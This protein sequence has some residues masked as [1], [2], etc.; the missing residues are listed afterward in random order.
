[1]LFER[2]GIDFEFGRA[3]KGRNRVIADLTRTNSLFLSTASQNAHDELLKISGFFRQMASVGDTQRRSRNNLFDEEMPDIDRRAIDFLSRLGTGVVDCR[4]SER[5]VPRE[6]RE[7]MEQLD[8]MRTKLTGGG[9]T[10]SPSEQPLKRKTLELAHKEIGGSLVYWDLDRESEGTRRLL[11]LLRPMLN[12][13]DEGSLLI[14]DELD[15]SL[16]TQA[17]EA[18]LLL[19][20]SAGTNPK[21]A[22][23]VATTHDTNLLQCRL[24]RRD[25]IWFTEKNQQ[26][27]TDLYPLTDFRTRKGD[28]LE[29]GYLQGR[30]GA[31]PF[32]GAIPSF[33]DAS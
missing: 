21:G 6:V 4:I 16:H 29:R 27:A 31:V 28:R 8:G 18:L 15:A 33:Q 9:T 19:F 14:V 30:Y 11:G 1:L 26:G 13:L 7:F 22:Q 3:L 20:L 17:C 25:Q 2:Q 10:S 23:L 12:A 32:A 24:L 5:E